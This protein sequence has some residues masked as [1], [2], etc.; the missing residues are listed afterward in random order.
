LSQLLMP[1]GFVLAQDDQDDNLSLD[2][3][4]SYFYGR[5]S[6]NFDVHGL[7]FKTPGYGV[8]EFRGPQTAREMMSLSMYY[9]YRALQPDTLARFKI[10]QAVID[11][12]NALQAR[13]SYSQS[14]EDAIAQLL[15]IDAIDTIPLLFNTEERNSIYQDIAGRAEA[16]LLAN[17]TSNRAALSAAYWQEIFNMLLSKN[18]ISHDRYDYLSDL[19]Y[20][21]INQVVVTDVTP[22]GW[23]REDTPMKFDPHYHVVTA[24]AFLAYGEFSG[25]QEFIDLSQK[26]TAN[27]RSISFSNGMVEAK[28]GN[29]PAGLGAQFYLMLGLLSYRFG[30]SDYNTYFSYAYG[31]RFFSD[32]QY[33]NRLEYHSTVLGTDANY[34]DDISFSNM[35]ELASSVPGFQGVSIDKNYAGQLLIPSSNKTASYS[36]INLDK[37]IY[38]GKL[39]VKQ[40]VNKDN[41]I[42]SVCYNASTKLQ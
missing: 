12:D 23:Y 26:M 19:A 3:Y 6:L 16:G 17:D 10:R 31:D 35:G 5:Y 36:V 21:K 2:N 1:A 4:L 40:L 33:P 27:I 14:F 7:V 34:H 20:Q 13:P 18:I 41:T 38:F 39:A 15:M 8:T 37:I 22:D 42:I 24:F 30:F 29:R 9:K 32:S 28:I 11:A 25:H